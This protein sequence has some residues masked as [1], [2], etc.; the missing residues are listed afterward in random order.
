MNEQNTVVKNTLQ[1]TQISEREV[2]L[3]RVFNAPRELVWQALSRP[4]H[5]SRWW[6]PRE[7][8]NAQCEMDFREGGTYRFVSHAPDGQAWTFFGEYREIVPPTRIVQTFGF[9]GMPGQPTVETMTLE[10]N[11]GQ[12]TL[13]VH[14]QCASVEDCEGMLGSGMEQGAGESYDRMEELL[15]ELAA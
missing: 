15:A 11:D 2:V 14:C 9:E 7:M 4:E 10:E 6:G 1:V 12:T 8:G 13:R 5:I 3:T